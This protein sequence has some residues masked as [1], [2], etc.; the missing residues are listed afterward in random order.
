MKRIEVHQARDYPALCCGRL[1]WMAKKL[2]KQF[3]TS[4]STNSLT[5]DN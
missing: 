1:G 3:V 2:D 4:K 5:G